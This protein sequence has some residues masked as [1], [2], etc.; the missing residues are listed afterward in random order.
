M[1]VKVKCPDCETAI[2]AEVDTSEA[3]SGD[4]YHDIIECPSCK[5]P[6]ILQTKITFGTDVLP[7]ASEPIKEATYAK[8][9]RVQSLL[10]QL[11]RELN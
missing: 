2:S 10:K 4:I 11:E 8:Q 5:K 9:R 6:S 3:S 1:K 7:V